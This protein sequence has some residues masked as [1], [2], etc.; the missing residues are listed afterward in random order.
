MTTIEERMRKNL[1]ESGV[2]DEQIDAIM[3][4][5]KVAP[6]NESMEGRWRDDAE[7]Y[8]PQLIAVAWL[9][10]KRHTL[11]YID[12]NCPQA[13]FRALFVPDTQGS[14]SALRGGSETHEPSV[15][16]S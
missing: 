6:E 16:R 4:R 15:T 11:A 10:V 8:P 14:P 1:F 2:F 7:G 3:E 5:V 9:T 12:E 13:W